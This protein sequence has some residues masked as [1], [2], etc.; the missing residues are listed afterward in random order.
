MAIIIPSKRGFAHG[1]HLDLVT[2]L[3]RLQ[4]M[5]PVEGWT[6]ARAPDAT[7]N[8][9]VTLFRGS[10]ILRGTEGGENTLSELS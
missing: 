10:P 1:P 9:S 6:V 4:I 8:S 3:L 2:A 5:N 7:W